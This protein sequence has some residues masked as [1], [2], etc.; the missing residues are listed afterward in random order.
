MKN[1]FTLVFDAC[2]TMEEEDRDAGKF[3]L[4]TYSNKRVANA[5]ARALNKKY[6]NGTEPWQT[7]CWWQGRIGR[8]GVETVPVNPPEEWLWDTRRYSKWSYPPPKRL[9]K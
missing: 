1:T 6:R 8:F 2:G 9:R 3:L 4:A 7:F 5:R